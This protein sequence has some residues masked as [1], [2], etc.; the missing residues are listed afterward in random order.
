MTKQTRRGFLRRASIGTATIGVLSAVSSLTVA[1]SPEQG[2][3]NQALTSTELAETGVNGPVV[4]YI[5][6]LT[7]GDI[8]IMVGTREIIHRDPEIIT[9]VLQAI[10]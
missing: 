10:R 3:A 7:K 1:C 4:A 2:S 6:D 5:G 8:N 9:R